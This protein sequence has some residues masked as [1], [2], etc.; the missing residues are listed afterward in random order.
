MSNGDLLKNM[1]D[2]ELVVYLVAD[3]S[4]IKEGQKEL[5]ESQGR[6]HLKMDE[7]IKD[8][9][10]NYSDRINKLEEGK[11]DKVYTNK[12][13]DDFERRMKELE[14]KGLDKTYYDEKH[15]ELRKIV[16]GLTISDAKINAKASQSSVWIAYGISAIGLL[17]EFYY[18]TRI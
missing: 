8:L 17:L 3:V 10:T 1:S 12:V 14:K 13:T 4:N 9:R 7:S 18:R 6:F 11:T 2:R 5:K 16:E 15:E